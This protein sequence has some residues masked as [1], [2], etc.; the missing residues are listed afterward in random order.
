LKNTKA[1]T[2]KRTICRIPTMYFKFEE[3]SGG[4]LVKIGYEKQKTNNVTDNVTDNEREMKII[5]FIK[6]NNKISTIELSK[7]L[8]VTKRT[9]LR[10]IEKLKKQDKLKRIGSEKT[11][12]W[13]VIK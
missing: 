4:Y 9:I 11:G 1:D 12:C 8:N 2:T 5:E 13:K 6:L 3:N 7:L 10:D